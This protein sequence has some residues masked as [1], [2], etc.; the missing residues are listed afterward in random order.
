MSAM[1]LLRNVFSSGGD[2]SGRLL[3]PNAPAILESFGRFEGP[4]PGG[5][6]HAGLDLG[7]VVKTALEADPDR[8]LDEMVEAC[9]SVGG[10]SYYGAWDILSAFA[11]DRQEDPRY[12]HIVDG[13][14][15]TLVEEG[16]GPGDIPMI[17]TPRAIERQRAG[18]ATSPETE[19]TPEPEPEPEIPRLADGEQRLLQV[20]DRPDGNQNRIYLIHRRPSDYDDHQFVAVIHHSETS[21][22]AFDQAGAWHGGVDERTVY[23]RVAEAFANTRTASCGYWLEPD[24]QWFADRVG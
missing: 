11:S 5:D 12:V 24:V 2:H 10:W 19:S 15:D 8:V 22:F 20:V 18:Q 9:D 16:Y 21:D 13:L 7:R 17:L 3:P 6:A 4:A 1:G 23:I 14:L